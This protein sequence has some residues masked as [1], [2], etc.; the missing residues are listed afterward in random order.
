MLDMSDIVAD[1]DLGA[2]RPFT[3]LRSVGQ[4]VEGGFKSVTTSIQVSGVVQPASTKDITMLPEADKASNL[5]SFWCLQPIYVTRGRV[6]LP[7]VQ[8]C[9]PAGAL[10]GHSFTLTP[11]PPAS[12]QGTL[13]LNG[14]GQRPNTY[15]VAGDLLTLTAD[16]PADAKLYYQWPT[17]EGVGQAASD[18]LVYDSVQYRILS[19][20]HYSG[21]GFYKAIGTRMSAI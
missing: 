20:M 17:E 12:A 14:L 11:A 6:P 3:I 21:S 5:M 1:E 9:V 7:A 10:P 13:Y 18:I 2:P 8:G 4:F 15:S 16:A 19:S